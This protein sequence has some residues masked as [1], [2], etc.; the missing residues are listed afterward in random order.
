MIKGNVCLWAYPSQ[1]ISPVIHT[2]EIFLFKSFKKGNTQGG[3]V[4][5]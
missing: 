4:L 1:K 5:F 2:E 3:N